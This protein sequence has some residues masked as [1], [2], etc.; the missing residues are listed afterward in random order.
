MG[1]GQPPISPG[2]KVCILAGAE[3]PFVLRE[4]AKGRFFLIGPAYVD[5]IMDGEARISDGFEESLRN[6]EIC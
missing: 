6:F 2:D 1:L 5:D 3:M 4:V